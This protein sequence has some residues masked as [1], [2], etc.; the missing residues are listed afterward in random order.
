MGA[1]FEEWVGGLLSRN[2]VQ[3]IDGLSPE[4]IREE[5]QDAESSIKNEECWEM[6]STGPAAAMH[7]GNAADLRSYVL[8]LESLLPETCTIAAENI[9]VDNDLI[10]DGDHVNAYVAAWFDVDGRFGTQTRGTDDYVSLYADYYPEGGRLEAFYVIGYADGTD[11][12]PVTVELACSERDA[13]LAKMKEAGLDGCVAE[14][15][16]GMEESGGME[17]S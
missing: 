1:M 6:G 12:C 3:S 11:G 14:M 9:V 13:I 4:M 7:R 2:D 8:Y 16:G 10:I 17:F 15:R 5:I